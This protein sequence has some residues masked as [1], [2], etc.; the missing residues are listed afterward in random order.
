MVEWQAQC[1][2]DGIWKADIREVVKFLLREARGAYG[3]E[4]PI[5]ATR[6]VRVLFRDGD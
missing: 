6:S 4:R 2:E 1:L 5:Q 3:V